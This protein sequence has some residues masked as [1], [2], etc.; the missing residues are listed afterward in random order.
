VFK[1]VTTGRETVLDSFSGPDGENPAAVLIRDASGNLYG[2]T[3]AGGK[4]C[5]LVN[6]TYNA[7]GSDQTTASGTV[8]H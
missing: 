3:V 8:L 2:T 5:N 6:S 7:C 1:L 4:S